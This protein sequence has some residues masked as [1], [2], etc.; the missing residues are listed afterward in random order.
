[1]KVEA[2]RVSDLLRSFIRLYREKNES[3][4]VERTTNFDEFEGSDLNAK[5]KKGPFLMRVLKVFFFLFVSNLTIAISITI[6]YCFLLSKYLYSS[7]I[8]LDFIVGF[9]RFPYEIAYVSL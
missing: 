6:V 9:R 3:R 7:M 4:E 1:M 5:N 8:V 2:I